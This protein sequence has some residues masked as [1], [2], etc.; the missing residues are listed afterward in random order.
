MSFSMALPR[1]PVAG[2][3]SSFNRTVSP[4]SSTTEG[5]GWWIPVRS[6]RAQRSALDGA[7]AV[8]RMLRSRG[9]EV[10]RE[11]LARSA[12]YDVSALDENAVARGAIEGC[13]ERFCDGVVAR[14]VV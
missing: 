13:A 6:L 9:V 3:Y 14:T 12:C 1:F 10:G 2:R 11:T 8:A 7:R 5:T 4:R